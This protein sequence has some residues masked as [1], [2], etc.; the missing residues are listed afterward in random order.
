MYDR[1]SASLVRP[2]RIYHGTWGSGA[3][4]PREEAAPSVIAELARTPEWYL[5]LALLAL[6]S[7]AAMLWRAQVVVVPLFMAGLAIPAANACAACA[8]AELGRHRRRP[9][10]ALRMRAVIALLHLA[11]PAARLAGRLSLGLAPWR[12]S[13]S[14][15]LS[16]PRRRHSTR[17]FEQWQSPLERV[18]RIEAAARQAG[19]RIVRGGPYDRWDIEISGG[20]AGGVRMLVALED[21][22]RG[23]QL[24]RCRIWPVIPASILRLG[25]GLGLLTLS[26]AR[27]GQ[28]AAAMVVGLLLLT[29]VSFSLW[30]C[31][32]ASAGALEALENATGSEPRHARRLRSALHGLRQRDIPLEES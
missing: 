28:D 12:R 7:V 2:S 18:A 9:L 25:T 19:A 15:G 20:A 22:G 30:E 4:Q 8:R 1:A 6:L 13:R 32:M 17:W 14:I 5:A 16:L 21:H 26:T 27:I 11:Q 24:Q 23:R 3:F 29:L 10:R 31:A